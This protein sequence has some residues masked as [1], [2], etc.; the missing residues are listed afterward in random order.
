MDSRGNDLA[1]GRIRF[2]TGRSKEY[3]EWAQTSIRAARTIKNWSN[4][5][6]MKEQLGG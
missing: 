2:D 6:R 5:S 4:C 1:A 3:F